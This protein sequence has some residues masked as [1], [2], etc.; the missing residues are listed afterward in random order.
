MIKIQ[1]GYGP[2][3]NRL[4]ENDESLVIRK[5]YLSFQWS[6]KALVLFGKI[7]CFV[8]AVVNL[9]FYMLPMFHLKTFKEQKNYVKGQS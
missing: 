8:V 1:N 6:M 3:E 2:T 7:Q 9:K 5:A 4:T